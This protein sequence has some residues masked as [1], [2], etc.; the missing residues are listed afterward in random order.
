MAKNR[1]SPDL[2]IKKQLNKSS[3]IHHCAQ[4]EWLKV[5]INISLSSPTNVGVSGGHLETFINE[6]PET[7]IEYGRGHTYYRMDRSQLLV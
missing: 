7:W 6:T 4:N 5:L 1:L 2:A 3:V